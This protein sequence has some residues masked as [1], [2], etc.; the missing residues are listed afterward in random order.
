MSTPLAIATVTAVLKD[1]LNNCH[2]RRGPVV[3]RRRLREGQRQA[4]G[5]A[6]PAGG[7]RADRAQYLPLPGDAQ[8]G[9]APTLDSRRATGTATAPAIR[10]SRSTCITCSPRRRPRISVPRSS[11]ASAM[12]IL[13][14]TGVLSRELIFKALN[15]S[16]PDFPVQLK[17]SELAD[18]VEQIRITPAALTVD[19]I[20]KLWTGL[21]GPLS[22][23]GGVCGDGRASSRRCARP[24]RRCRSRSATSWSS[25]SSRS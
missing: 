14:E 20:S 16:A 21:S 11:W 2:D 1:V 15:P 5:Q 12:Q 17:V 8:P 6:D 7:R 24:A 25:R 4:A 18:Q 10:R 23:V 3:D 22:H 9:L 19:D 13:H